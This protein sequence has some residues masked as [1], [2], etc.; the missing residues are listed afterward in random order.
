MQIQPASQGAP[1]EIRWLFA[2]A[3]SLLPPALRSDWLREWSAELWHFS[4]SGRGCRRQMWALA[5]GAVPDA[6]VLLR[7]DY[8]IAR[9]IHD[10]SQSRSAPAIL[11]ALL[12]TA[13][14]LLTGGFS[15]GRDLLFHDDSAGLV[16]IAQP[17]PFMGGS[18]RVPA[19]Q[20]EGWLEGSRTVA[21][22]GRWRM[23]DLP[24][25]GR[26]SQVCMAD[27]TALVLLSEAPVKPPCKRFERL[28]SNAPAFAG[29]V[30]RLRNG[31]SLGDAE[32]ELERTATPRKGW[33]RPAI[34]PLAA[35]RKAPLAPVGLA[36]LVLMLLSALAVRALAM[37]A[38]IWAATEITLAFA[39]IAG[40]WIEMAARAPFTDT[41]GVPPA[42]S[43]GLYL[44]PVL[45]GCCAVWRLRR[46][47]CHRCR[48]CYRP[49]TMPVSVGMS[50]RRL[51]EPG[52]TEY[53]CGA[54]HPALLADSL[55]E[56]VTEELWATWL[57]SWT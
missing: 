45:A 24:P 12:A 21:E 40:V 29:V 19:A 43:A 44:L 23:E 56:Q 11:F 42:W 26:R 9:R 13:A 37:R 47:V 35:I 54:G 15:R 10:V 39:C 18:S 30:A 17:I 16:L 5:C 20:V 53:L 22:L 2:A 57:D 41:A 3:G 48:V 31:A 49:L 28:G 55:N 4:G 14:T 51:F 6:W 25:G 32:R 38:W 50:G 1:V 27:A 33:V 8:G 34:V 7:Q 46:S 36:L 52:G